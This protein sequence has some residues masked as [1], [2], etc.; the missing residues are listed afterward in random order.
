MQL[1]VLNG[2]YEA[3]KAVC[4]QHCNDNQQQPVTTPVSRTMQQS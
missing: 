4:S 2:Y 3:K 1:G